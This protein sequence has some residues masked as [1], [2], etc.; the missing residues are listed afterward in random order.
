MSSEQR[1]AMPLSYRNRGAMPLEWKGNGC[2]SE[3]EQS[4]SESTSSS[5]SKSNVIFLTN[6]KDTVTSEGTE[7]SSISEGA[8][9]KGTKSKGMKRKLYGKAISKGAV[10]GKGTVSKG[11]ESSI[12][13]SLI[14]RGTQK[15]MNEG[16]PPLEW[17]FETK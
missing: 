16:L 17:Q 14:N 8:T 5:C 11:A 3:S 12:Q 9:S 1:G 10:V 13:F 6:S 2:I 4:G 15:R 7:S